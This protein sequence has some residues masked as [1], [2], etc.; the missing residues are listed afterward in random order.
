M[1]DFVMLWTEDYSHGV[2]H[3]IFESEAKAKA[4]LYEEIMRNYDTEKEMFAEYSIN[5][6]DEIFT[7]QYAGFIVVQLIKD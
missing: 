2:D 5:S 4:W 6:F 3:V 7:N 1:D